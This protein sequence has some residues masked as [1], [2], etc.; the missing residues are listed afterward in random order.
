M[1]SGPSSFIALAKIPLAVELVNGQ[2]VCQDRVVFVSKMSIN[3]PTFFL[4]TSVLARFIS[5][6]RGVKLFLI[7]FISP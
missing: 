4:R 3:K 6:V 2:L 1:F 5:F 7:T